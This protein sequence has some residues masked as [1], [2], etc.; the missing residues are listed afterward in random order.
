[1]DPEAAVL[2]EKKPFST[3]QVCGAYNLGEIHGVGLNASS[4]ES[5]HSRIKQN[6]S[7]SYLARVLM[8]GHTHPRRNP[9]SRSN[10]RLSH[11]KSSFYVALSLRQAMQN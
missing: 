3:T 1:M 11:T 6:L 4:N 9:T 2:A 5:K 8:N 7:Q 10:P